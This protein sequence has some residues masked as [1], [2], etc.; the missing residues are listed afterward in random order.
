MIERLAANNMRKFSIVCNFPV[1]YDSV[2]NVSAPM[3][4]TSVNLDS[5]TLVYDND[6]DFLTI[7]RASG[8]LYLIPY[9][10]IA[11]IHT[12]YFT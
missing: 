9:H 6:D 11:V 3:V 2:S 7:K 4:E 10:S 12:A 5:D 1:N 8:Q